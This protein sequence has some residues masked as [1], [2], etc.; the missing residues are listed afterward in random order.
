MNPDCTL[1]TASYDLTR[2]NNKSRNIDKTIEN[3]KSLLEVPCYLVVFTDHILYPRISEFRNN[4]GFENIT[5]YIIREFE[6]LKIYKYINLVKKNREIYHPTKDDRTSAEIHLLCCGKFD[7]VLEI[8]DTNPFNTSKFGWIDS[9]VE[10]GVPGYSDKFTKISCNYTNNLIL[11]AMYNCTDKFHIQIIYV[12]DKKYKK[13]EHLKEYYEAYRWVVSGCFFLTGKEIGKKILNRLNEIFVHTTNQ[14]YGHAE[15]MFYITVLDEYYDDIVKSYGDY[16]HTLN[17][18]VNTTTGFDYIYHFCIKN[19]LLYGYHKECIECC[20]KVLR[21][22]ENFNT[23]IDYEI[24]FC[25]LVN[26]Y[27][28]YFYY[29]RQKAI[30]TYHKILKLIEENPYM[31]KTYEGNKEYFDGQFNYILN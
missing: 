29:D 16:R 20:L 19:Y 14:G 5:K 2:F 8:I 9:S 23:E 31:R 24:Y 12:N 22:I 11:R 28:A 26:L 4:L 10:G 18:F 6:D 30:D 17:N 1:V 15:E 3:M 25:I 13:D 27:I 21:D 7:F